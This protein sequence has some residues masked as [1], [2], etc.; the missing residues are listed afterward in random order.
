[1]NHENVG[2]GVIA[3]VHGPVPP[4]Y[5]VGSKTEFHNPR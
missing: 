4:F 1:V 2:V 5:W 3:A